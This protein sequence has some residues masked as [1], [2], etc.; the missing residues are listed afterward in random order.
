MNKYKI[1]DEKI[2]EMIKIADE[3]ENKKATNFLLALFMIIG[4]VGIFIVALLSLIENPIIFAL[5]FLSSVYLS[6]I[7]LN[8]YIK[9]TK[10]DWY[11]KDF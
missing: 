6:I 10:K 11:S 1:P 8:I 5:P 4:C 2:K 7:M 9:I 3:K